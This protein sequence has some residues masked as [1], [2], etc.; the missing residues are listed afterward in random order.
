MRLNFTFGGEQYSI[1]A[2]YFDGEMCFSAADLIS[3]FR[4][5]G[6]NRA[7]RDIPN[8]EK[9]FSAS[10]SFVTKAGAHDLYHQSVWNSADVFYRTLKEIADQRNQA[11]FANELP[12]I[13][14]DLNPIPA[15]INETSGSELIAVTEVEGKRVVSARELHSFLGA[16]E[17]FGNWFDRQMQYGFVE[18]E[19]YT[20]CEVFNTLANQTLKDYALTIDCAKEIS[21]LQRSDK[22]KEARQ[23]FIQCERKLK[24]VFHIPTNFA[25][26]LQLAA[27]Q[28]KELEQNQ[29]TI[30]A[31]SQKIEEDAPKVLMADSIISDAEPQTIKYLADLL[32]SNKIHIGQNRL[33]KWLREHDYLCSSASRKNLPQQRYLDMGLFEVKHIQKSTPFGTL[34]DNFQ[35]LVTGKGVEYFVNGFVSGKF[36]YPVK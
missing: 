15:T 8:S 11:M 29:K 12:E 14:P 34:A 31:Q 19:D 9:R 13:K 2:R 21:M 23:Y 4:I 7:F 35:T 24:E 3:A 32:S 17:R 16:T 1:H 18:N 20:G 10:D 27:N 30:Q 22:G 33:F 5:L 26:A 25:E 6:A 28:A 36:S